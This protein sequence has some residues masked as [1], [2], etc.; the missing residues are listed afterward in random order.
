M[1][2]SVVGRLAAIIALGAWPF[3]APNEFLVTVV[4][5][6]SIS[7]IGATSLHLIIRTG[8]VSLAHAAFMGVGCYATVFAIMQLGWPFPFNMLAGAVAPALLA[9]LIGPILLRLQGK[10]FILVTFLLGEIL[11]LAFVKATDI[12]GGANGIFGIPAPAPVFASPL[13]QYYLAVGTAVACVLLVGHVLRSGLGR[14]INSIREGERLAECSGV[15]V[16]RVKVG[17]FMLASALVGLQG[18]LIAFHLHYVDPGAFTSVQSLGFL[19]MNVIGGME[20]LAGPLLGAAFMVA[21]PELLRGYVELQ[22]VLFG[23]ILIFVIAA[24]PGGIAELLARPR[25]PW[26]RG[27]ILLPGDTTMAPR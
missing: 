16:L 5:L 15:P 10:Y 22:Q 24:M 14:A 2:A 12:T 26:K 19:V 9:L 11:R 20:R 17:V 13:G 6:I 23:L 4:L 8:H 3:V 21:M 18:G 7:A 25:L 1:T 27:K